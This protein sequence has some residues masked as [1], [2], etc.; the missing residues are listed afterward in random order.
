MTSFTPTRKSEFILST[1]PSKEERRQKKNLNAYPSPPS[2]QR[3]LG[4]PNIK[5]MEFAMKMQG[6]L[7]EIKTQFVKTNLPKTS[8]GR[9]DDDDQSVKSELSTTRISMD[10]S[11]PSV[12]T[13]LSTT[14]IEQ[15]E[16]DQSVKTDLSKMSTRR[17]ESEDRRL[18]ALEKRKA[19][20][21]EI[22][23]KNKPA[24]LN[25]LMDRIIY[26]LP[27]DELMV[28]TPNLFWDGGDDMTKYYEWLL[29]EYYD[30]EMPEIVRRANAFRGFPQLDDAD[31][32]PDGADERR[33][34]YQSKQGR[35]ELRPYLPAI[36][37]YASKGEYVLIEAKVNGQTASDALDAAASAAE[38]SP[39]LKD[40]Q[41]TAASCV[42]AS[43][44]SYYVKPESPVPGDSASI[45]VE[46]LMAQF[47]RSATLGRTPQVPIQ[48][49]LFVTPNQDGKS[50]VR[51]MSPGM[52][53][54]PKDEPKSTSA[55]KYFPPAFTPLGPAT[56]KDEQEDDDKDPAKDEEM[57]A[58][59]LSFPSVPT[60]AATPTKKQAT[61]TT[62]KRKELSD[63]TWKPVP[64][65]MSSDD[66]KPRIKRAKQ[67][68]RATA[69]R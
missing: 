27:S 24:N 18:K 67:S 62:R 56:K 4:G 25:R 19:R 44:S 63:T 12:K 65:Y 46:D 30:G 42:P 48:S 43:A 29:E 53:E 54:K 32:N 39:E 51:D 10:D 33:A 50:F 28:V 35:E 60:P 23:K 40:E 14:S 1:P 49:S 64:D 17:D 11:E 3:R 22:Q 16:S 21:R 61:K 47:D 55:S 2:S 34:Y 7:N 68:H 66:E 5:E 58:A 69:R 45:P 52:F 8:I 26:S 37:K 9:E 31:F 57:S 15:C 36:K 59:D 13:R 20:D 38:S 6:H 41:S